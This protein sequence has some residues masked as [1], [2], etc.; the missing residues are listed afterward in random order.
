MENFVNMGRQFLSGQQGGGEDA[1]ASNGGGLNINNIISHAMNQNQQ[2]GQDQ[3]NGQGQQQLFGQVANFLQ[4]KQSNGQ[5]DENV[6]EGDLMSSFRKITQGS[7]GSSQE[8]G[9]AAAVGAFKQMFGQGGQQSGGTDAL[10]GKALSL[11]QQHG[12]DSDAMNHASETVMKLVMKHKMQSM[13]G[14][15]GGGNL[16][17][18]MSLLS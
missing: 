18:L 8:V 4:H 7:N 9:Q 5:I 11:V 6:D 1:Q 17:G 15:G 14:G 13:L 10:I 16:S 12:G 3:Q 2:N